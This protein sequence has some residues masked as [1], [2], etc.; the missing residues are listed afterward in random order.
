MK[1]RQGW[2]YSNNPDGSAEKTHMGLQSSFYKPP[3]TDI[4]YDHSALIDWDSSSKIPD[5]CIRGHSNPGTRFWEDMEEESQRYVEN[6]KQMIAREEE[7][8]GTFTDDVASGMCLANYKKPNK[9]R[10]MQGC[11]SF[12]WDV[13]RRKM[14]KG[15]CNRYYGTR[16]K[17][18][19]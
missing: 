9:P 14:S 16:E 1:H 13:F 8:A 7:F 4:W 12:M 2:F 19:K 3:E 18:G 11:G 5:P 6:H 15:K 17:R 10:R